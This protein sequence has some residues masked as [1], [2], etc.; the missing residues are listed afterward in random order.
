[1]ACI[2]TTRFGV[3]EYEED[4]VITFVSG[5]L[6]FEQY[7]RYVLLDIKGPE[8]PFQW[9]QSVEDR[10]LAFLLY[11]P[12]YTYKHYCPPVSA[13]DLADLGLRD[14]G[15]AIVK[16]IVTVPSDPMLATANFQAP[17]IINVE[18]RL[19]KQVVTGLPS[20]KT[21][22]M[23]YGENKLQRKTG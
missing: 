11:D 15:C 4:R 16:C 8:F 2:E 17:L 21:R 9:L 6:G 18:N 1:M 5:I 13:L 3:V 7:S 22:Q 10:D 20:Y 14:I 19:A 23:I 12:V